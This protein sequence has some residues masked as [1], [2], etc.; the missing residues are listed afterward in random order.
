MYSHFLE[1][2]VAASP[3]KLAPGRVQNCCELLSSYL[4]NTPSCC[5]PSRKRRNSPVAMWRERKEMGLMFDAVWTFQIADSA[6]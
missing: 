3:E 4:G 6:E 2:V 5:V 1:D